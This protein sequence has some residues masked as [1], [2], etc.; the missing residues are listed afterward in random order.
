MDMVKF[1]VQVRRWCVCV[2][3]LGACCWVRL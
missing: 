1:L 2:F 3:V